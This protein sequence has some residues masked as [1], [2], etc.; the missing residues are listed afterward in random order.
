MVRIKSTWRFLQSQGPLTIPAADVIAHKHH[1]KTR[2]TQ[3]FNIE[4]KL[5]NDYA[6]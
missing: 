6:P 1:A 2:K 4:A 3:K 5:R